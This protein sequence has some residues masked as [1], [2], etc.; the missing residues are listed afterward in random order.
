[1]EYLTIFRAI[2]LKPIYISQLSDDNSE[3]SNG[4]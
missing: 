1:M 2:L 3:L 4:F